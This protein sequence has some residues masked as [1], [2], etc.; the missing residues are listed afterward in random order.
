MHEP[1][2]TTLAKKKKSIS[3]SSVHYWRINEKSS[4]KSLQLCLSS[5]NMFRP[6]FFFFLYSFLNPARLLYESVFHSLIVFIN[7]ISI[8]P[9]ST[10]SHASRCFPITKKKR[11]EPAH[12]FFDVYCGCRGAFC[13]H[14]DSTSVG[15][16]IIV[17]TF[18]T[19]SLHSFDVLLLPDSLL[20]S[21]FWISISAGCYHIYPTPPLG[22]DMTQGQFFKAG[23][24]RFEFRIFL[25]LD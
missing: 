17:T 4:F 18:P 15:K 5:G 11:N 24:N 13:R 20:L 10:D 19:F 6:F 14:D 21:I 7:M 12:I 2:P 8:T 1:S 3:G 25:L 22:Q 9:K 23:F 16:I